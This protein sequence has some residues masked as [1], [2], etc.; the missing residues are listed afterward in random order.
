MNDTPIT[1]RGSLNDTPSGPQPR[2]ET[3]GR[4]GP[5]A[6]DVTLQMLARVRTAVLYCTHRFWCCVLFQFHDDPTQR[7]RVAVASELNV[8]IDEGVGRVHFERGG[9]A[10]GLGR[11]LKDLFGGGLRGTHFAAW[12]WLMLE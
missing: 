8:E 4:G 12:V 9:V 7:R 6:A 10:G 3:S 1:P 2:G 5:S 11:D